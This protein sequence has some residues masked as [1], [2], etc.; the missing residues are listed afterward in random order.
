MAFASQSVM[1]LAHAEL[2]TA[3]ET[4]VKAAG[5]ERLIV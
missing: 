2:A 3:S 5:I 1:T 4:P